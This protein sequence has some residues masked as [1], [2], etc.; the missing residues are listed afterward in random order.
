MIKKLITPLLSALVLAGCA[1]QVTEIVVIVASEIEVD[2]V[3][4]RIARGD[5]VQMVQVDTAE[6]SLPFT[7]TIVHR[8]GALAPVS[9]RAVGH[10]DGQTVEAREV[11]TFIGGETQTVTLTLRADCLGITCDD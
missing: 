1:D 6:V 7:Q 11:T 4:L 5:D 9:L 3:D 2:Q 10:R 8:G